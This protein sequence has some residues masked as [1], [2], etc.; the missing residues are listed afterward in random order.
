MPYVTIGIAAAVL[1]VHIFEFRLKGLAC[2]L[3]AFAIV[4]AMAASNHFELARF[5]GNGLRDAEFKYLADW[6]MQNAQKG[7][8]LITTMPSVV[9][10]YTP[11]RRRYIV[12]HFTV[13]SPERYLKRCYKKGI[14]Y[15]A[16]D[17]RVGLNIG[18]RYYKLW[19]MENIHPLFEPRSIGPY[20]FITQLRNGN[21][22]INI[23]RL[24]SPPTAAGSS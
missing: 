5:M 19:R 3:A 11:G 22:Y 1:S 8:K 15:I 12:N 4:S 17:S 13:D 24:K 9:N 23:F 20:E 18:G 14:T 10:L 6:Y 21:R 7:E 2:G 16:W